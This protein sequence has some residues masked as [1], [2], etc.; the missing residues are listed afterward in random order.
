MTTQIQLK[1]RPVTVMTAVVTMTKKTTFQLHMFLM[2]MQP[3]SPTSKD[4][5][6]EYAVSEYVET[7]DLLETEYAVGSENV[8]VSK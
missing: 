3:R 1:V 5:V 2:I 7:E 8:V 4:M 6:V